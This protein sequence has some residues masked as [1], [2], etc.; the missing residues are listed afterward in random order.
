M[1][2][3]WQKVAY[4]VTDTVAID[5]V[6]NQIQ[7]GGIVDDEGPPKFGR[8]GQLERDGVIVAT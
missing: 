7:A 3:M 4:P 1:H 5:G 2:V 6:V 8:N